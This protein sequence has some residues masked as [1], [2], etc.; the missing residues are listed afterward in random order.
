MLKSLSVSVINKNDDTVINENHPHIMIDDSLKIIKQKLFAFHPLLIPNLTKFEVYDY[1]NQKYKII[2]EQSNEL[3]YNFLD[4]NSLDNNSL[5]NNSLDNNSVELYITMLQDDIQNYD[6]NILND[7]NLLDNLLK[8]LQL[9][10]YS[11]LTEEDLLFIIKFTLYNESFNESYFEDIIEYTTR[12]KN[13]NEV[14]VNYYHDQEED[15]I[16]DE[17]YKESIKFDFTDDIKDMFFDDISIIIKG[18]NVE[19]GVKGIFIKLYEIFNVLELTNDIP[20]I[21]L[22][23][24]SSSIKLDSPQIKVLNTSDN[25]SDKDI[26]NWILNEK[27]KINQS[28][29]KTIKGLLV[30]SLLTETPF[31]NSKIFT[32]IN[33]LPNGLINVNCKLKKNID[34]SLKSLLKIILNNT[35]KII[36]YINTF[37]GIFLHSKRIN[38]IDESTVTIE[39]IDCSIVTNLFIDRRKFQSLIN[40]EIISDTILELKDTQSVD[41]LSAYYKKIQLHDRIEDDIKGITINIRDNPYIEDSSIINIFSANN[42]NQAVI[43]LANVLI[44]NEMASIINKKGLFDDLIKKRRIQKKTNKKLL[45]EQGINFNS[46][47]CQSVK[48]PKLNTDNLKPIKDSYLLDFKGNNYR[49]DNPIYPYPGFTKTNIQ[50][51]FKIDQR[52]NEEFIRNIDPESL[53]IWVE[54]SNFKITIKKNNK[55]YE[56]LV[57]KIVSEYKFG[58]DV[59][60]SMPTYYFLSPFDNHTL[61]ELIPITNQKLIEKIDNEN[62]IFLDRVP[63]SQIIY[64]TS[65]KTKCPFNPDINN[66]TENINSQCSNHKK[67]S[68]FGYTQ[69]AIPCC[70]DKDQNIHTN[71]KLKKSDLTGY[72]FQT[73]KILNNNRLG[74]LPSELNQLFNIVFGKNKKGVYYKM[75]IVQ[76]NYSFLNVILLAMNSKIKN[77]IVNNFLEFKQVIIKYLH[78]YPTEFLRLNNGDISS[79]YT[80][81][82]YIKSFDIKI[83]WYETIELLEKIIKRNILILEVNE[84]NS[85]KLLCRPKA[86]NKKYLNRSFI[87]LIKK[88]NTFE[89]IVEYLKDTSIIKDFKNNPK[90]IE[91]F[92]EYYKNSCINKNVYPENFQYVPLLYSKSVIDTLS[93]DN[94]LGNIKYQIKNEFN[95]INMLMTKKGA[96][97]PII[98]TGIIDNSN[99]RVSTLA[100]LIKQKDKLLTLKEYQRVIKELNKIFYES[101]KIKILGTSLSNINGINGLFLNYGVILP[102]RIETSEPNI[103]KLDIKYYIDIDEKLASIDNKFIQNDYVKYSK[104]QNI[105]K[106]NIFDLRKQIGNYIE[107]N[108]QVKN[109]I[110]KIILQTNINKFT[111][112]N[113]IFNE[114]NKFDLNF[115]TDL[116]KDKLD[117]I[118]KSI[119]N[120]ICNDNKENLILNNIVTSYDFN[121]N[122]VKK[123]DSE[124]VLLNID[125][126]YK[127]IKKYKITSDN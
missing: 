59:N 3:L 125:D 14:N 69:K 84:T 21:A 127:W 120:E 16:F 52:G 22:G 24:R 19:Q 50:C 124:S 38:S 34:I 51:C 72:I 26:K 4:N 109:I 126:I 111:K 39:S 60:N 42:Y 105:I 83:N 55:V 27:K 117:I 66:R 116:H 75:G 11:N 96:L 88:N 28:S 20:L 89:L 44:I 90:I 112:I 73:D 65:S 71:T 79:K 7:N 56:T 74:I 54:P 77:T 78:D 12:M 43:I 33:I 97:I 68:Y 94:Y 101:T 62:N 35:D 86:I 114:F 25:V 17:Y 76:N 113:D 104:E 107:K 45:K 85:S 108:Q 93:K 106:N 92:L 102:Y 123:R 82:S 67:H 31:E 5:D 57:I 41:I 23:K 15:K 119:A 29:Y 18:N 91:F 8:E 70:F 95:K 1:D 103:K 37:H 10:G 9:D 49:C 32:S 2:T 36:K 100:S 110:E 118:L 46:R 47:G 40:K 121:K 63:L 13:L 30:K 81:E 53:N 48:Q 87:I 80:L 98:E 61:R 122:D 115:T 6:Y 99:I 58:F 64:P